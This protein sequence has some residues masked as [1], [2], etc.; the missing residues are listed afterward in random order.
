VTTPPPDPARLLAL[1][2][3]EVAPSTAASP[4]GPRP[5]LTVDRVIDAAI[6]LADASGIDAVTIR[7]VAQA[8]GV[9]PMSVYTYVPGKAELLDLMLDTVY[10]RMPRPPWVDANWRTR[11][12]AIAHANRALYTCHPWVAD[13]PNSRPP[14]G[15]GLMA[16]YQYELEALDGL[17]LGDVEMDAALTYVLGFVEACARAAARAR[18]A[19]EETAMS[20]AAWWA[21]NEPLLARVF[22]ATRYPTAARVGA[23]AGAAH[24]AAYDPEHSFGFGLG[25]VLD[26]LAVLITPG[27]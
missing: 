11:V 24:Q 6:T 13:L 5:T 1:L 2:W 14:L 25:R 22:D 18:A 19:Q 17:G 8:L 26:G 15:P 10:L 16:K 21:A 3:R 7:P 12:T 20:D 4:R 27:G 9:S 23:A